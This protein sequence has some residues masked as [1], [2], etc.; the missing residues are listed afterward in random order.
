[1]IWPSID[2]PEPDGPI[3]PRHSPGARL[4][5]TPFRNN[6]PEPGNTTPTL[7]TMR[8][9]SASAMPSPSATG[10]DDKDAVE[11]PVG[12]QGRRESFPASNRTF[13]GCERAAEQQC[14]GKDNGGASVVVE[15][16]PRGGSHDQDLRQ[17]A[18]GFGHQHDDLVSPLGHLVLASRILRGLADQARGAVAHPHGTDQLN[19]FDSRREP[20][21]ASR[22]RGSPTSPAD[23]R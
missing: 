1:M 18:R 12:A 5:E 10:D 14:R 2:L 13:D 6:S 16:Q 3:M 23:P 17:R 21:M 4:N 7:S 19:I 20:A 22:Q 15:H 11:P 8:R 9:P